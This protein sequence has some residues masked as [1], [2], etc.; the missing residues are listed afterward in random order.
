MVS[1]WQGWAG[2][3]DLC[4]SGWSLCLWRL[5]SLRALC[6]LGC[7]LQCHAWQATLSKSC[8]PRH[9]GVWTG[10]SALEVVGPD[11]FEGQRGAASM[12][13]SSW[14]CHESSGGLS[15][16]RACCQPMWRSLF[17]GSAQVV[18][19]QEGSYMS[20]SAESDLLVESELSSDESV[21]S[22]GSVASGGAAGGGPPSQVQGIPREPLCVSSRASIPVFRRGT[23]LG[24]PRPCR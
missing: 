1:M 8:V 6:C 15:Q 16:K 10:R 3:G 18:S 19:A 12:F 5:V 2:G 13:L 7:L 14:S 24:S 17:G 21:G 9:H 20:S 4:L 23:V 11:A 22:I